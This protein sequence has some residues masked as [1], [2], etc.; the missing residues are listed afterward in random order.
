MAEALQTDTAD[1]QPSNP[2]FTT[3]LKTPAEVSRALKTMRNQ[4]IGLKL[5]FENET[6]IYTARILD[7][8]ENELLIE[9]VHPRGGLKLMTARRR[10]AFSG[11]AD[12]LYLY[13][14]ANQISRIDEDRGVP[15]FRVPL[16]KNALFQQRR[17]AARYQVPIRAHSNPATVTLFRSTATDKD[18]GNTLDGRMLDISAGGCRIAIPGPVHPPLE[19]D[20]A[21][22]SLSI[23]IPGKFDLSGQAIIR[24]A[25]YNKLTRKVIC[26]MEFTGMHVTD[27]R[28]LEQF[29]HSLSRAEERD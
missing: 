6:T 20:E 9:D 25:S 17:Q 29:I 10:F 8:L 15:Y 2:I 22:K 14:E 19:T 5:T 21:L 12:G 23:Q 11:R 1:E 4:R 3:Y 27:R 18:H 7:V 28:R 26:G 16:P 24:H 13:S